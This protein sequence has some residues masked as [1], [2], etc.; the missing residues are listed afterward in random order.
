M[1][2]PDLDEPVTKKPLVKPEGREDVPEGLK[3]EYGT[4]LMALAAMRG[5][6]DGVAPQ[7]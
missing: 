2:S 1:G 4:V 7:R 3:E 6:V 5:P